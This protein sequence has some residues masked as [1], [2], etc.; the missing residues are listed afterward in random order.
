MLSSVLV[1][2]GTSLLLKK[3]PVSVSKAAALA[4]LAIGGFLAFGP[5]GLLAGGAGA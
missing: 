1:C 4:F 5:L 3:L 2:G